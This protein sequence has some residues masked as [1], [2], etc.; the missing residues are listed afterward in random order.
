[1][2]RNIGSIDSES[3]IVGGHVNTK[4]GIAFRVALMD[5]SHSQ[6]TTSLEI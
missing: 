1:M 4:S 5:L 6:D 2:L 3:E